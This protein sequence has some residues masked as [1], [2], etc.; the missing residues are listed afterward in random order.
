MS[1]LYSIETWF[2]SILSLGWISL[3]ILSAKSLLEEC[4]VYS[5]VV[6]STINL[7]GTSMNKYFPTQPLFA[8]NVTTTLFY[9]LLICMGI[10]DWSTKYFSVSGSI[11]YECANKDMVSMV[12]KDYFDDN[13]FFLM[14]ASVTLGFQIMQ[15]F[16]SAAAVGQGNVYVGHSVGYALMCL[17]C[18]ANFEWLAN[19]FQ[20]VCP[21]GDVN[22]FF[23]LEISVYL[24]FLLLSCT[25]IIWI[26]FEGFSFNFYSKLLSRFMGCLL[27]FL[28][29]TSILYTT[30][31]RNMLSIPLIAYITVAFILS[32]SG[33]YPD[34]SNVKQEPIEERKTVKWI[35]PPTIPKPLTMDELK[36]SNFKLK[37]KL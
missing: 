12:K 17:I 11:R 27:S 21:V 31:N 33:I 14:P 36:P 13:S 4:L 8:Y 35:V 29:S 1:I 2:F 10:D 16:T 15:L 30:K 18:F 34:H 7:I 37:K 6:N 25:F 9:L 24:Y 3:R 20:R 23:A 19:I 26:V 22:V 32:V 5:S 28:G